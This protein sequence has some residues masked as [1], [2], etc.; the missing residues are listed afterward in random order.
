MLLLSACQNAPNP[1]PTTSPGQDFTGD[2]CTPVIT[3]V[4]PEKVAML[5][6]LAA[7]FKN[8]T[9]HGSLPKCAT[10]Y[11]VEVS[12]GEAA[13]LLKLSGELWP[14]SETVKPRP[15]LWT[16]ASSAWIDQVAAVNGSALVADAKSFT[17]TPVVFAMPE[18]MARTLG[19]PEK[20]IG[21]KD[22]HDLCVNPDGWGSMGGTAGQWGGFKLG[23]TNPNSST[24]GLATL[25]MQSYAA[26]GKTS[27][28]TTADIAAAKKFSR[29][30]ESCVIHYGD[31]TGNMLQR[32]YDRDAEGRPLDYVSAIAVEEI[33]VIAYNQGN[34]NTRALSDEEAAK[35]VRP[36]EKLVAVYPKEGSLTSDNPI[37]ALGGAKAGWVS[38][39]QATAG[40]AFIDFLLSDQVQDELDEYGFRPLDAQR[41]VNGL[42][43]EQNG[44]D[45]RQPTTWLEK[46]SVP[47]SFA[48]T[49][50]WDAIRKPSSVLVLID[51][52][53][54]MA[55]PAGAGKTRL[56][57]AVDSAQGTLG[58]FRPSDELGVWTFT[59]GG[60][61]KKTGTYQVRA[62]KPLGGDL[63]NLLRELKNLV[64]LSGTPLYDAVR[65]GYD[66]MTER[67]EPG[68]I[69]AIV[70]LSDGDDHG[71]QLSQAALIAGLNSTGEGGG[72]DAPVRVFPIVYGDGVSEAGRNA[73]VAIAEA[74]GGQIFDASD[75]RRIAEVF[76]SVVN[77]F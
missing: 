19:W 44:V 52:S 33:S 15:T 73:L 7:E 29:E 9:Q 58:H 4:S 42:F 56:E 16:P 14:A 23:K 27:G 8:S 39:E 21:I 26:S 31:T 6:R 17:R 74:S 63:E 34:P 41:A 59:T 71:S 47:V 61:Y 32:V 69:N 35:L 54:S 10:I 18:R 1:T 2:N 70:L 67:A 24:S 12:S 64:P 51:V 40:R 37:V 66:A 72:G 62:V 57:A 65:R 3:A 46:P 28:L 38:A 75:P 25:V 43:T 68:R 11:P 50:Q 49:E 76:Q 36:R 20:K 22:L 13:R 48:A 45:A 30:F 55:E 77:N 60:V 53:G 5:T